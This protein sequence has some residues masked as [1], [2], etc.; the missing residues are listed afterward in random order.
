MHPNLSAT[1]SAFQREGYHLSLIPH[2]QEPCPADQSAARA[3]SSL[4]GKP[5]SFKK[6]NIAYCLYSTH[7]R[8][9]LRTDSIT[10]QDGT[11]FWG[12]KRSEQDP[13]RLGLVS[14]ST[15]RHEDKSYT[16]VRCRSTSSRY[17]RLPFCGQT[18]YEYCTVS[19]A[20]G[21]FFCVLILHHPHHT[22]YHASQPQ[23]F[24][25]F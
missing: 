6:R 3:Y 23:Y 1:S 21:H 11:A 14:C 2:K 4:H 18:L 22:L 12:G 20:L 17:L 10:P 8:H 15:S 13:R 19:E 16:F 7:S 24:L 9:V 25:Q 5:G